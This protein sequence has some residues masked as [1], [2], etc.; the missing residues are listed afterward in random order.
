MSA[1]CESRVSLF[2]SSFS[3]ICTPPCSHI[4]CQPV[5]CLFVWR[6]GVLSGGE[7]SG[8]GGGARVL[9]TEASHL[10]QNHQPF[11]DKPVEGSEIISFWHFL[12]NKKLSDDSMLPAHY[13]IKNEILPYFIFVSML[14]SDVNHVKRWKTENTSEW[15]ITLKQV[16]DPG[17]P[18][19]SFLLKNIFKLLW[20]VIAY[21]VRG[22]QR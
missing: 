20:I 4:L 3:R 18:V 17:A 13:H 7:G 14:I 6:G 10:D 21:E 12:F 11:H 2:L 19:K 16:S 15:W 9:L 1:L 8:V 22:T 5:N